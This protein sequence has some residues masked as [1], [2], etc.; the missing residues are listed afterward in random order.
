MPNP[1]LRR[2]TFEPTCQVPAESTR[3][4]ALLSTNQLPLPV[5]SQDGTVH[6]TTPVPFRRKVLPVIVALTLPTETAVSHPVK[7]LSLTVASKSLDP[8]A[9]ATPEPGPMKRSPTRE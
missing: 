9:T 3:A 6:E 2:A 7:T 1:P 8:R 5:P 4:V